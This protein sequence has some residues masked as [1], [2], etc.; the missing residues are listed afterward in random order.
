MGLRLFRAEEVVRKGRGQVSH[1][2]DCGP[3]AACNVS[4]RAIALGGNV[5]CASLSLSVKEE[6]HC[7]CSVA[8][9][10]TVRLINTRNDVYNTQ[11]QQFKNNLMNTR[12]LEKSTQ[13]L[14]IAVTA[15]N[16]YYLIQ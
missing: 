2:L 5:A 8:E 3:W 1:I 12:N 10:E 7:R 13:K 14:Y 15:H 6:L 16:F 9:M 11:E 4:Q